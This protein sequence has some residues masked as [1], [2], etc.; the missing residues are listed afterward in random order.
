MLS[1]EGNPLEDAKSS[2]SRRP[3][4]TLRPNGSGR[5]FYASR[6]EGLS[7]DAACSGT[8]LVDLPDP[9][10]RM[11]AL[12]RVVPDQANWCKASAKRWRSGILPAGELNFERGAPE[13]PHEP[14]DGVQ[15]TEESRA[16]TL[17]SENGFRGRLPHQ[18]HE[19][20]C[21]S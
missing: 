19:T 18:K 10:D 17:C 8:K 7:V 11:V 2:T 3:P 9:A 13:F 14:R 16:A 4:P 5:V 20:S 1:V 15:A 12:I 21:C 6:D